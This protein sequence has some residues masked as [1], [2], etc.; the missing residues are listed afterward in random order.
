M[1]INIR[2]ISYKTITYNII[3]DL[4]S[5][6]RIFENSIRNLISYNVPFEKLRQCRKQETLIREKGK[7]ILPTSNHFLCD[8]PLSLKAYFISR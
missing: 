2:L 8:I 6:F 3:H 7:Q 5:L 1:A 4:S